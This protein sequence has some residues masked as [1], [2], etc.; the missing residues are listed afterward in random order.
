M[1]LAQRLAA[2]ELEMQAAVAG[3][4]GSPASRMRLVRAR[5]AYREAEDQAIEVISARA[6]ARRGA[7]SPASSCCLMQAPKRPTSL[8]WVSGGPSVARV[9]DASSATYSAA[10]PK[11]EAQPLTIVST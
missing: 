10:L 4:D 7:N 1:A 9:D 6:S 3:L 11:S 2:V 8:R 5:E